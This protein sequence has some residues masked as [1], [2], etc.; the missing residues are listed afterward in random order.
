MTQR[1]VLASPWAAGFVILSLAATPPSPPSVATQQFDVDEVLSALLAAEAELKSFT[2]EMVMTEHSALFGDSTFERG[3][4]AMLKPGYVRREIVEPANRVLVVA[5]GLA[6][7]FIPRIKQVQE[8]VLDELSEQSGELSQSPTSVASALR[9][10]FDSSIAGIRTSAD[11]RAD[12]YVLE[13]FPIAGSAA[14]KRWKQVTL[15]V[16]AGDWYPPQ[17]TILMEHTDDTTMIELSAVERNP[18]LE[19]KDFELD[20]PPGVEIIRQRLP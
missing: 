11:G 1:R 13:M 4:L 20:L 3:T 15:W 12:I 2:A 19:P 10:E 14:A 6:R 18:G 8:Y 16:Q 9:D 5:D 17:R 7:L